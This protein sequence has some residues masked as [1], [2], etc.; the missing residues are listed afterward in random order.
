LVRRMPAG[1]VIIDVA[2]DQGGCIETS[3]LT[4]HSEPTYVEDGVIHYAVPNMPGAVPRTSTLAL[5]NATF[6]YVLALAEHG[7][8]GA[9]ARLPELVAGLNTYRG[10]VTH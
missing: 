4:S 5:S 8:R 3:R 6:P 7:V 10:S 1:A 9:L 2:I